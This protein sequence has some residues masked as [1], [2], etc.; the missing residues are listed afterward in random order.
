MA[1]L[2][3]TIIV[4]TLAAYIAVG[5][6]SARRVRSIEDYF[7]AGMKLSVIPLTGTYLATYFSGVSMMGY[8]GDLYAFGIS[9]LWLPI[10]WALGTVILIFVALRLK[11][12]SMITPADFFRLR[13]GSS[14]LE[15]LV[16][17]TSV[18]ALIFGLIVQYRVMGVA[19]SL[20]LNRPFEEGVMITALVMAIIIALGGLVSVAWSD[21]LKAIVFLIAIFVGAA[22]IL[23]ALGGIGGIIDKV[24]ERHGALLD[25]VGGYTALGIFFLFFIWSLGVGTHPQYLQRIIAAKDTRVALLQYVISWPILALVYLALTSLALGARVLMPTLPQGYTRDYALPLLF[26]NYCPEVIYALYLAGLIAAALS[27][28]DSVIQ[29]A[30]SLLCVNVVKVVKPDVKLQ[31]LLLAGRITGF[32]LTILIAFLAIRPLPAIMYLA[33][34]SWGLLAVGYSATT[35]FGLYWRRAN[36]VGA[37]ASVIGGWIAFIIAQTLAGARLWP[38][39]EVPPVAVG[40]VTALV[41]LPI[42]SLLT[43]PPPKERVEPF[44]K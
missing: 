27:T 21:V 10:F 2:P 17:I 41:L 34:Y 16:S 33:G 7:I 36:R 3:L 19:W 35:I 42:G 32:I 30:A 20:A 1:I 9:A 23:T 4:G 12:A 11:K 39:K 28:A 44:F 24:A 40:V 31:T 8:P 26:K 29:L 37:L 5:A 25:P 18:I 13:Y 6:I 14:L 22:W 15:V 43:S 38:L